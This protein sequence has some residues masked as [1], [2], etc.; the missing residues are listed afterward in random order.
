[1]SVESALF[2]AVAVLLGNAFFVGAEFALVSARR[3]NIELAALNGSRMAKLTLTA[4]EQ[5]SLMLAGAQLGVTLCSLILGAVG[6]P[7]IANSLAG[8]LHELGVSEHFTHPIAF[9]I[10]L[11]VMVYAHV[12]IGEMVPKNL[13]LSSSTRAALLLV[14]VLYY[15]VKFTRPVV[16][17]LNA[18]AN[19][20]LHLLGITA[21]NEI[22]SSFNRDEV[23]GFIKESHVGGLLSEAEESLLSGTLGFDERTVQPIIV[24]VAKI[25]T[26]SARPTPQEIEQL[27]SRTGYSRFPVPARDGTGFKGYVHAKDVLGLNAGAYDK[28]V[29]AR[30]IR[31][32]GSVKA[33]SSLRDALVTMQQS[34]AHVTTVSNGHGTTVG[35]V[36]LE[37]ILEE[38]VGPIR[39]ETEGNILVSK[40]AS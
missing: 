5:V 1:M 20:C 31:P 34:G 13:S 2:I 14:P 30:L 23:A 8:P 4:M 6:E 35:V 26:T 15:F 33:T 29:P 32:L 36:M 28:P 37:D 25:I 18:I 21:K 16:A 10:A 3:S 22:R 24:P 9:A 38:L 7:L 12:V 19:G 40:E 11:L 39:D 27:A 17:F